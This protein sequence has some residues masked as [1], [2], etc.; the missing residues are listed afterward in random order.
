LG[1]TLGLT[2]SLEQ[3][4]D[5]IRAAF[6]LTDIKSGKIL[7]GDTLTAPASD[8]FTIEDKLTNGVAD[9][10]QL[11]LR[12]EEK[13]ALGT[14]STNLPEA[15]QYYVQGRGYLQDPRKAENLTSA[16]IVFKQ[17]LK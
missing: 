17:A 13:Q 14:H 6:S 1:V 11:P 3:A 8:L 10:L 5:L 15:Y 12:S 4:N 16:E 7:G 9:A 2:V